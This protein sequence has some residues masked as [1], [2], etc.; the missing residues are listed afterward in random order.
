MAGHNIVQETVLHMTNVGN[1]ILLY[2]G[3]VNGMQR[4]KM[5][6]INL[7]QRNFFALLAIQVLSMPFFKSVL[8]T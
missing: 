1:A 5:D 2:I 6:G 7:L 8:L 4:V 3:F